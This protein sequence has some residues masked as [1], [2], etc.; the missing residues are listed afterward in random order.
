MEGGKR[1]GFMF[2]AEAALGKEHHI[3]RDDSSL[4]RAPPGFDSIIAK[5]GASPCASISSAL[6]YSF[7]PWDIL[8]LHRG[9]VS[10]IRQ[11]TRR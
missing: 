4:K 5:V 9:T 11:R 3:T 1:V 6:V 10:R 2:L 8:T 7:D